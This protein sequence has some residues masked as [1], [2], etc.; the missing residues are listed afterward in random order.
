MEE[1]QRRN[2]IKANRMQGAGGTFRGESVGHVMMG[3]NEEGVMKAEGAQEPL[4][5][6]GVYEAAGR[7]NTQFFTNYHPELIME[8]LQKEILNMDGL[9]AESIKVHPKKYRLDFTI[10]QNII[11]MPEEEELEKESKQE[12]SEEIGLQSMCTIKLL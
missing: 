9:V 1:E 6:L 12:A 11:A 3:E 7:K 10:Y 5:K 8:D 4:K 2:V